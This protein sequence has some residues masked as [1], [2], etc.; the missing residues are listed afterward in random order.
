MLNY[1]GGI[2][3]LNIPCI[4]AIRISGNLKTGDRGEKHKHLCPDAL[5]L[6]ERYRS[7][8]PESKLIF[9]NSEGEY[10]DGDVINK[11]LRK[12]CKELDIPYKSFYRTRAYVVTQIASM[13]DYEAFRKTTGYLQTIA[14]LR[15]A[16]SRRTDRVMRTVCGRRGA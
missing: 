2:A 12:A 3:P 13:Y 11:H 8:R 5:L 16:F 4:S 15:K 7:E 10:L 14:L 6:L 9:P 1:P